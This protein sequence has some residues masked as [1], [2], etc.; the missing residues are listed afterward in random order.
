M[1]NP[2]QRLAT[3]GLLAAGCAFGAILPSPIF[4]Q[5]ERQRP[6]RMQPVRILAQFSGKLPDTRLQKLAPENGFIVEKQ[7]WTRLWKA[8]RG[9]EE[10]P[11]IDF[12]TDMV[13][14]FTADGP[15]NVGCEPM[16]AQNGDVQANAMSTLIGGPGFGYLLMQIPRQGV[17]SVN[18]K[19][20][21]GEKAPRQRDPRGGGAQGEPGAVPGW[22][23]GDSSPP[24]AADNEGTVRGGGWSP[25]DSSPRGAA[26][27]E[28]TVPGASP[29]GKGEVPPFEGT[30]RRRPSR[31]TAGAPPHAGSAVVSSVAAQA[32]PIKQLEG[33]EPKP[34]VFEGSSWKKPIKISSAEEAA[35]HFSEKQL[36]ELQKQ[37]DFAE[38]V[39]LLFAW[40]GSGQDR[41]DYS[42]AES[43][44]EQIFFRYSPGRTR[45]YRQHVYVYALRKNVSWSVR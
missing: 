22:S 2:M 13:L 3:I 35:K 45:D 33:M 27:H 21:P 5:A 42:V 38:Q 16:L 11:D 4:G 31:G 14:V 19:P 43:Y 18:G 7:Q 8:W 32:P 15:N 40:R 34:A 37:V 1:F 29:G 26:D 23:P 36:G 28:G 9:D 39:V 41:L 12:E 44:P 6:K 10:L 24:G 25:G 17:R 20:L 30:G